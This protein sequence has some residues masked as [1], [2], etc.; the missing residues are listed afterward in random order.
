M[1]LG[2]YGVALASWARPAPLTEIPNREELF[3]PKAIDMPGPKSS[4]W[5]EEAKFKGHSYKPLRWSVLGSTSCLP[6]RVSPK[7]RP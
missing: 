2:G 3:E 1:H 6:S 7:S 4:Q 5:V